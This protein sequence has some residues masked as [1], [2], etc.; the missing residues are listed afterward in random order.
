MFLVCSGLYS[1][2]W[3]SM[4]CDVMWPALLCSNLIHADFIYTMLSSS[5]LSPPRFS[6]EL[7]YECTCLFLC[8]WIGAIHPTTCQVYLI[9]F[10]Y[11]INEFTE[12]LFNDSLTVSQRWC[13]PDVNCLCSIISSYQI[14]CL[15][16]RNLFS[17]PWLLLI[18]WF[19][20]QRSHDS[21]PPFLGHTSTQAFGFF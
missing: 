15:V 10:L 21:R 11:L 3:R 7:I 16:W 20:W 8:K 17:F 18:S 9:C 2:V 1:F 6:S 13:W 5:L 14:K 4:R 19:I 12:E